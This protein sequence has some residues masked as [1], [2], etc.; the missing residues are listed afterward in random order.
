[1]G[2]VCMC[3]HMY[4]CITKAIEDFMNLEDHMGGVGSEWG[5]KKVEAVLIYEV[6]KACYTKLNGELSDFPASSTHLTYPSTILLLFQYNS[7]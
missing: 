7:F 2:C 4:I 6:L 1:M 5:R 3:I